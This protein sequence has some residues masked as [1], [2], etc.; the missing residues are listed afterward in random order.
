MS[1]K[2]KSLPEI[3]F[4]LVSSSIDERGVYPHQAIVKR[5][6][7][8]LDMMSLDVHPNQ[9]AEI[10]LTL[11]N[12]G[13]VAEAIFALDRSAMPGQGTTLGDLV[14]GAH[15]VGGEFKPFVIEYQHEPRIVKPMEWNNAV[16]NAMVTKEIGGF[17]NGVGNDSGAGARRRTRQH[18]RRP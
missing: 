12:R 14:A 7:G 4:G 15:F 8:K 2:E 9:A 5:G 13:A 10:V 1:A 3:F 18:H 11:V 16:W 17:F 6:G